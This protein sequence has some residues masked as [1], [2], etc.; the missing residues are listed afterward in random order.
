[1]MYDDDVFNLVVWFTFTFA[2]TTGLMIVHM[3]NEL[4]QF[5]ITTLQVIT[6]TLYMTA[7]PCA[8]C[9]MNC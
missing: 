1:M 4:Y 3:Q 7:Q 8:C 6:C 9:L 5:D 2:G